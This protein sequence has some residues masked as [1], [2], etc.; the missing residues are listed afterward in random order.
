M[1]KWKN[2][3]RN[4]KGQYWWSNGTTYKG[5]WKDGMCHGYGVKKL[6]DGTKYK[7]EW[8]KG[9]A[10]GMGIKFWKADGTHYEGEWKRGKH[11]GYG[12][13]TFS[14][15]TKYEGTWRK[16]KPHN[17]ALLWWPDGRIYDIVFNNGKYE[18]LNASYESHEKYRDHLREVEI[19]KEIAASPWLQ[20]DLS[21]D[22]GLV[23]VEGDDDM[24]DAGDDEQPA[25]E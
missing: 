18:S 21:G 5:K 9:K 13:K 8:V 19:Q 1:G 15:G 6:A 7:G 20:M 2:G 14:D 25:L 16:G 3:K 4:G 17:Q 24:E 12:V 23:D 11:S 10:H 22:G